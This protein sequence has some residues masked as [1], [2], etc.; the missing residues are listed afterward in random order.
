MS[1]VAVARVLWKEFLGL[2]RVIFFVDHGGVL[3]CAIKGTSKEK[4]WRGL[5][6]KFEHADFGGPCIG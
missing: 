5:L 3:A 1:A 4:T 2:Q 6:L